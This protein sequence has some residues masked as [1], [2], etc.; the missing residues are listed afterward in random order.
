MGVVS[1]P[2]PNPDPV[3]APRGA[4]SGS[5]EGFDTVILPIYGAAE[6]FHG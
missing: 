3:L 2:N 6:T 5:V 4:A 1:D